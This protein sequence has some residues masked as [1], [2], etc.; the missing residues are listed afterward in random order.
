[1][2]SI[3]L[4]KKMLYNNDMDMFVALADP[5]RRHI[6]ELLASSGELTATAIYEQF[7]TTPQAISQHLRILREAHLVEM[8]KHAQKH[9]YRLNPDTLSQFETWVQQTKQRWEE[10]FAALDQVLEREKQK[11]VKDEHESR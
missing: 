9:L 2:L 8:E 10:R 5:T 11:L 7:P 6:L 1:M 4:I 3:D